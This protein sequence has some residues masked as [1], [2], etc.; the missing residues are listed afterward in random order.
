MWGREEQSTDATPAPLAA[1]DAALAAVAPI[2]E[3]AAASAAVVLDA[4]E[5]VVLPEPAR[6]SRRDARAQRAAAPIVEPEIG[7]ESFAMPEPLPRRATLRAPRIEAASEPVVDT[8]LMPVE[9]FELVEPTVVEPIVEAAAEPFE[10]I[11]PVDVEP[12]EEIMTDDAE[13]PASIADDFEA[14]ARLFSFTGETPIIS[15]ERVAPVEELAVAHV[16]ARKPRRVTGAVFKRVAATSFSIGVFGVV[17]LMTV[18]MTTPA[19]AVAAASGSDKTASVSVVAPGDVEGGDSADAEAIQAYVAPASTE[20]VDVARSESYAT[21]SM[22]EIA[23]ESGI[24]NFSNLFVNDPTSP[25]QWPFAVGVPMS[26]GFGMR[27]G[28]MHEGIDFTPG[29]GSPVQAIADG[30][31]RV[32]SESGGAYGV[33][34]IIDHI[35]DGQLVSS[36]YAHMQY[37]SLQVVPGQKVTVGTVV[38]HTGNTGRSFG[39]HTHF[40]ILQNGT[41]P[42]DPLPWLREHAGG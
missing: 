24:Q 3:I 14:A 6:R 12:I 31:V 33:H 34:V 7:P 38:G 11:E 30:T 23:R 27:S 9:P 22:A 10:L 32:A 2:V 18:G 19:E 5:E 29:A 28:A 17:G 37:G 26:Y 20:N 8:V 36:H 40:E 16:A 42:I 13:D 35:I 15:E 41:T 25:I 21:V 39:A 4:V 1:A